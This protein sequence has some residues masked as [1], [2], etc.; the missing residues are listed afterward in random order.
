TAAALLAEA[1]ARAA[2]GDDQPLPDE[3]HTWIA[4]ALQLDG[5]QGFTSATDAQVALEDA[6][7]EDSEYVAAPVALETFL[8]R[9]IAA[10]LDPV[11]V[12]IPAVKPRVAV[13]VTPVPAA[14]TAAPTPIAAPPIP[15][16]AAP[17]AP[18]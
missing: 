2:G 14:V 7:A 15:L 5:R 8:S 18:P 17:L 13:A 1:R 6:L 10:M 9:Y 12:A 4:R 3:L 11:P 16:A